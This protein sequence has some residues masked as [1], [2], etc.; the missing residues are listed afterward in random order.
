VLAAPIATPKPL[1]DKLSETMARV[2][3]DP[4]FVKYCYQRGSVQLEYGP[5]ETKVFLEQRTAKMKQL[6]GELGI[7]PQ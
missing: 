6:F 1:I 3:K 2:H 7:K 5:A 4:E